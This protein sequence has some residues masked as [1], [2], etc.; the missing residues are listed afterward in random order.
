MQTSA[1]TGDNVEEAFVTLARRILQ[2]GQGRTGPAGSKS[3]RLQVILICFIAL[4]VQY[5]ILAQ[6]LCSFSLACRLSCMCLFPHTIHIFAVMN[7]PEP[8]K[9][10]VKSLNW[11]CFLIP[12][13]LRAR[14]TIY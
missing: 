6:K 10:N 2:A 4:C 7:T 12:C 3:V 9:L 14:T 8:E 11:G 5:C 1:K 13:F